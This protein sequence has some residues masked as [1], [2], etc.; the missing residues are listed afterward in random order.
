[1]KEPKSGGADATLK[2]FA[3]S[4]GGG[5]RAKP[6]EYQDHQDHQGL[7][8]LQEDLQGPANPSSQETDKQADDEDLKSPMTALEKRFLTIYFSGEKITMEQAAK[9]AGFRARNKTA[10]CN[11]ARRVLSKYEGQTDPREIFRRIGLGEEAIA[12]KLLAIADDSGIAA[13]TR[14]QALSIASKCLGLQREVVEGASGARIV[15][16][17]AAEP[18]EPAQSEERVVGQETAKAISLVK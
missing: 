16:H 6:A 18:A 8:D 1:M 3:R 15:I 13:G 2:A 17:P 10:L 7:Q 12:R 14:V 5:K 9:R 11:A 4:R